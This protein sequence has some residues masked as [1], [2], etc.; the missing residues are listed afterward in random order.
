MEKNSS[1]WKKW[2]AAFIFGVALITVYKTFDNLS[3][4]F[5]L[6]KQIIS[7]FTPFIIGFILAFFL[8]P[9]TQ[10]LETKLSGCKKEILVKHKRT[11]SVLTVYFSFIALLG[12]AISFILPS[13]SASLAEF[14]RKLPEYIAQLEIFAADMVKEGG[15]LEKLHLDEWVQSL[16]FRSIMEKTLSKDVWSYVEGV[17]GITSTLMAWLMGIVICAY[18]LLERKSLLRIVKVVVG[19]FVKKETL[20]TLG[21]YTAR[22]S[23]IFY[24]FF[25]GKMV[26]SLIIGAIAII[27][28]ILLD[29]PY[30]VLMGV[31]V[32]VFN[33]IPYFGP[34]IG[35]VPPI[36]VVLFSSGF[37]PALWIALFIFILQQFDGIWLGPKILGDSV[38]VSPFWVI[39]AILI[40]GGI[41][42]FWG[43]LFG[44]PMIAAIRMLAGDYLDD[45]KLN[46]S[47]SVGKKEET[48]K[49]NKAE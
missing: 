30:A 48:E 35:A 14:L 5:A 11:I 27:G 32:M 3:K 36:L 19:F 18:T 23:S 40:F 26:D 6:L 38:G 7:L 34:F 39:F 25:F 15:I 9:L 47:V 45:G 28:F 33:M 43:M 49:E 4:I 8:Y 17:R 12:L 42:G 22:I 21:N 29:V 46:L 37:Y 44:V 1:Y 10:K 31:I 13:L 16:N 24:K 2:L 20:N 41:F